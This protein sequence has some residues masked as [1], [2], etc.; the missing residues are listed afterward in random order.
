M[1]AGESNFDPGAEGNVS[2]GGAA[3]GGGGPKKSALAPSSEAPVAVAMRD[4]SRT[5]AKKL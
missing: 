4:C 1:L 2:L 3:G 5:A